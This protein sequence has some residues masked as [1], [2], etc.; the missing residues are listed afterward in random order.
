MKAT[1]LGL[2][3]N[4]LVTLAIRSI[5]TT[6][7]HVF[8]LGS[9]YPLWRRRLWMSDGSVDWNEAWRWWSLSGPAWATLCPGFFACSSHLFIHHQPPHTAL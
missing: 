7:T 1:A 8:S 5:Y 9:P 6:E 2:Y 3:P 4:F